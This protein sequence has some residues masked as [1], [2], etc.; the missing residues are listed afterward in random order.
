MKKISFLLLIALTLSVCFSSLL[1][2]NQEKIILL[3]MDENEQPR[4]EELAKEEE[5]QKDEEESPKVEEEPPREEEEEKERECIPKI[6]RIHGHH[7]RRRYHEMYERRYSKYSMKRPHFKIKEDYKRP[8]RRPKFYGKNKFNN[9]ERYRRGGRN[10]WKR[11][12]E[13][14]T[15][16]VGEYF[17]KKSFIQR[18]NGGG[19]RTTNFGKRGYYMNRRNRF[20]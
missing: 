16:Y 12:E 11:R 17:Q 1:E 14:K 2:N 19:K 20:Y 6:P 7:N 9:E 5:P 13:R 3:D 8:H 18:R 4:Q 10:I 15:D